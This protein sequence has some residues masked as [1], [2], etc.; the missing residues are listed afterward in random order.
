MLLICIC[1]CILFELVQRNLYLFYRNSAKCDCTIGCSNRAYRSPST[2]RKKRFDS[3]PNFHFFF[4]RCWHRC[5]LLLGSSVACCRSDWW[6]EYWFSHQLFFFLFVKRWKSISLTDEE[7]GAA[8]AT[9]ATTTSSSSSS[10]SSST[11]TEY[12]PLTNETV[13]PFHYSCRC[14]SIDNRMCF[15]RCWR[16]VWS[17]A[18]HRSFRFIFQFCFYSPKN[19]NNHFSFNSIM[20]CSSNVSVSSLSILTRKTIDLCVFFVFL[21]SLLC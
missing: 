11:A 1:I 9:S 15:V 14:H 20:W 21:I 6:F 19:N 2:N 7:G 13:A 4:I 16:T 12:A 3:F 8:G 10:S 17:K 5:C 18:T